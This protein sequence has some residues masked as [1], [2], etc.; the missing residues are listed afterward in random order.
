[1]RF[2]LYSPDQ[3]YLLPPSGKQILGENHLSLLGLKPTVCR[4][5]S[6]A[7]QGSGL[8]LCIDLSKQFLIRIATRE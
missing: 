1:M 5:D 2:M 4:K 3:A 7:A 6:S 8:Q